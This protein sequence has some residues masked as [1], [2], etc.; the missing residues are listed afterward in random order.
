M[1]EEARKVLVARVLLEAGKN[2]LTRTEVAKATRMGKERAGQI[3]RLL[4]DDG[5]AINTSKSRYSRWLLPEF[6]D[7]APM[8]SA[9]FEDDPLV[10]SPIVHSRIS[11]ND[12][13]RIERTKPYSVFTLAA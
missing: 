2:G 7:S 13:P 8:P 3:L 5:E 12:A 11:A 1:S 6:S 4:R 10:N 9:E